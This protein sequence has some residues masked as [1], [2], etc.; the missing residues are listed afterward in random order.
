MRT[1]GTWAVPST[2]PLETVPPRTL[3][4]AGPLALVIWGPQG[5]TPAVLLPG[6]SGVAG[7]EG[8]SLISFL[9]QRHAAPHSGSTGPRYFVVSTEEGYWAV[10]E[11]PG[12]P[13]IS[14]L[15]AGWARGLLP[16]PTPPPLLP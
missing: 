14:V 3:G 13:T 2:C 12:A 10:V 5:A 4:R 6:S 8:S 1:L 11:K 7:S 9:G 15:L 16:P